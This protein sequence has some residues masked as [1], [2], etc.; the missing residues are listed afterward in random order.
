MSVIRVDLPQSAYDISIAPLA[1]LGQQLA[2][3]KLGQT[4]LL[5]SNPMVF[6]HYGQQA[7]E[8]LE[9]AGFKVVT[10]LLPAGE[11]YKTLN[12]I[13][14]VYDQALAQRLERSS[15]MIALGGG[16]I[17]DMTGFAAATWLRGISFVQ[18]PTTLLAMVD[19]AIG[20]KTG[21]NHPNGKNL[22]GA[23]H[24][25]RL[26]LIDSATLQTLP[27]REFRAGMAE[28]IKYG[29]IWD[30]QLFER[31][32]QAKRLDQQRYVDADLMQEILLRSCQAKAHVVSKDEKEAGLRAILNYGHTIG[33]AVESLTGYKTVNH[34]EAVAIGMVAAGDLAVELGLWDRESAD[35]Q[36]ILIQKAGLP[37]KIPA[38]LESGAIVEA[39]QSDKKVKGG[40]VRFVLPTQIGAAIVT[41]QPTPELVQR[42]VE[43]NQK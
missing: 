38:N 12:S 20:G 17:G 36:L 8:S 25:P 9:Q 33:H 10:C 11:R 15:T 31:L 1:Q 3:L 32:E 29:I 18:V 26:V 4:V 16:V 41:D 28:V 13:Q 42:V 34:G 7:I 22:I 24:Q 6:R 5:V 14:K 2:D 19:A 39:L 43:K 27:P 37:T 30:A 21:V 40:K 23:F 35:R